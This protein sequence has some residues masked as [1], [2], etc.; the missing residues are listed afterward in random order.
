[1]T[2]ISKIKA[3]KSTTMFLID[4]PLEKE[5]EKEVVRQI[6]GIK[7]QM[8]DITQKE[9]LVKFITEHTDSIKMLE[10]VLGIS[11]ERMKRVV[12]MLRVQKGYTFDT[13]WNE[14]RLQREL[15]ANPTLM[16]E[17][18]SLFLRGREMEEYRSAIPQFIL[19]DFCI[20]EATV[21]RVMNDDVLRKLVKTKIKTAWTSRYSTVYE[22]RINNAIR[23]E[24]TPLGLSV[25]HGD[26]E[27]IGKNLYYITDGTNYIIYTF[28]FSLTTSA[29]QTKYYE[30]IV[31]PIYKAIH[32][33][34]NCCLVNILDGAGWIGRGADYKKIYQDCHYFLNLNSIKEIANI[35]KSFF[36]IETI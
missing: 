2:K 13:E 33:K 27:G 11:G 9:S 16:E 32:E 14:E 17:Y 26:L 36:N 23:D 22:Q 7:Q 3:I 34:Q 24:I 8:K 4:I 19:D 28:S 20:D 21:K 35:C 29:G 10:T 31:Q 25:I 30:N 18:C 12:N 5:F 15:V 6:D 1:M